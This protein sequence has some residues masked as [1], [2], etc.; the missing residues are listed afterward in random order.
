LGSFDFWVLVLIGLPAPSPAATTF[1]PYLMA[2]FRFVGT[3]SGFWI[4]LVFA[5]TFF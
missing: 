1:R 4:R 5:A 3:F 2:S